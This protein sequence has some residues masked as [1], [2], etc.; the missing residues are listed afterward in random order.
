MR[1]EQ[2][3]PLIGRP[4]VT[5]V[6]PHY[7]YGQYLPY[8][9]QTA[10][11]QPGVET[12][13]VIVDDASTDGSAE[14]ARRLAS[15]DSRVRLI[16]HETNRRHIATYNDGL[17]AATGKYVVLLSADDALA[18][19]SLAR[20]ASLLEAHPSVGLVYGSVR[21]FSHSVDGA[22]E[23]VAAWRG[24]RTSWTVWRGR[25][26]LE[27]V[28]R[29]GRN[30]IS[31]PEVVMRREV[32]DEIG[33]YD[34]RF[35]HSADLFLWLR[36][37]ARSDV[38]RVTGVVQAYYRVHDTNMHAVEFGGLL[39]DYRA[40]RDT[41]EAFY[42]V[43]G[44]RIRDVERLRARTRRAL[45]REA[46]HRTVLLPAAASA[47]SAHALLRYSAETDPT[48]AYA[49]AAYRAGLRMGLRVPLRAVEDLRW[50]IRY[51]RELRFGT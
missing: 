44:D 45:S 6:I 50:R 9:V 8:A 17:A 10:L 38:G 31:N 33:G 13:V 3:T 23:D 5:V 37:A 40:V 46:L 26:W 20:S 47:E 32:L 42:D 36:A 2:P 16:E 27:R 30:P 34:A 12:D 19:G 25:A 7:N 18:P 48:D 22:H 49:R 24:A 35:P 29:H 1:I 15:A 28:G 41:F 43:D 11:D 4:R 21:T 14:V 39:D 51:Q